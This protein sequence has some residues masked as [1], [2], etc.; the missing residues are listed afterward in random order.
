[1]L[2]SRNPY[3]RPKEMGGTLIRKVIQLLKAHNV[4]LPLAKVVLAV[5]GG[6]DSMALAHLIIKYGKAIVDRENISIIHV[7]HGWRGVHSDGDE[8]FVVNYAHRMEV[9]VK[10]FQMKKFSNEEL[11][12]LSLESVARNERKSF[13]KEVT[14]DESVKIFTAHQANDLSETIIWRLCTGKMETHNQGIYVNSGNEIRPFLS[15]TKED[16]KLFLNEENIDWRE[17]S[18]NHEGKLL[19]SKMRQ[20]LMPSLERIFPQ[21]LEHIKN[22]ALQ[23]QLTSGEEDE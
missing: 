20:E 8:Q 7:N 13:F 9:P 4:Q 16:L 11:K 19:R 23:N 15:S 3:P 1:M 21:A 2:A 22:Y 12:G 5:S 14:Q 18:T 17:D 6:S 10:V